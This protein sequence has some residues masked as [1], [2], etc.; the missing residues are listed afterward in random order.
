MR[1]NGPAINPFSMAIC[2]G[3]AS[4]TLRVRLLSNPHATQALAMASG[5][6]MLSK[7]GAPDHDSTAAPTTRLTMP[8]AIRRSKFSWKINHAI[9]AV[10]APSSVRRSEAAAA[11]VRASPNIS[12]SGPSTPPAPIA[13]ASQTPLAA[14]LAGLVVVQTVLT[15]GIAFLTRAVWTLSGIAP[16]LAGAAICGVGFT[17]LVAQVIPAP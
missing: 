4:D 16:R 14:Y 1:L 11:S 10:A 12:S 15:V 5:P 8:T 3:S 17:V 2:S 13:P 6:T 7:L 9:S